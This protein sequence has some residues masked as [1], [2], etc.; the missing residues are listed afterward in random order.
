MKATGIL[1][2]IDGLGRIVIPMEIR[3]K[4][5][6][7]QNDPLEIHVEGNSIVLRKYEPDCTFCGSSR[8]VVEYKGKNVCE[9]CIKELNEIKK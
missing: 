7:S 5:N 6:I 9:K 1:R 4:L 8:N 2:K 3:N